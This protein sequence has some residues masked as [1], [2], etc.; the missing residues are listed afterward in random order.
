MAIRFTCE[1]TDPHTEAVLQLL[2]ERLDND[3]SKMLK[4]VCRAK[5]WLELESP[6]PFDSSGYEQMSSSLVVVTDEEHKTSH[7][8]CLP[9]SQSPLASSDFREDHKLPSLE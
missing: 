8:P 2:G 4:V 5:Q 6:I 3:T 1:V 9:P 7:T